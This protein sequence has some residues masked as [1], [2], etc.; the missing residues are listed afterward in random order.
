LENLFIL[1]GVTAL[2]FTPKNDKMNDRNGCVK[3]ILNTFCL[4]SRGDFISDKACSTNRKLS[5][6]ISFLEMD[7]SINVGLG[8][9]YWWAQVHSKLKA[10]TASIRVHCGL[11]PIFVLLLVMHNQRRK[12]RCWIF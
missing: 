9:L 12:A 5:W 4:I 2:Y 10:L 3:N 1:F 11:P 6:S 8:N 7:R